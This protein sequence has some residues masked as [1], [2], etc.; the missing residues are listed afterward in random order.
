LSGAA[1][2]GGAAAATAWACS[3]AAA[4]W[5]YLDGAS[6]E[7]PDAGSQAFNFER[8]GLGWLAGRQAAC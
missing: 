1:A 2:N 4:L 6:A 3:R 8:L 7:L 5:A